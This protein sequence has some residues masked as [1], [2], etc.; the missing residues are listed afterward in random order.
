MATITQL[1]ER[2]SL[3]QY[4]AQAIILQLKNARY[5]LE[6]MLYPLRERSQENT[7]LLQT[8]IQAEDIVKIIYYRY[9]NCHLNGA[10]K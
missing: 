3:E 7:L 8:L 4:E 2:L 5:R 10:E 1:D 6:N 9:H